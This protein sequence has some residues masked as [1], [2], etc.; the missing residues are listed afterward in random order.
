MMNHSLDG[1]LFQGEYLMIDGISFL[2]L[3]NSNEENTK[4]SQAGVEIWC[5]HDEEFGIRQVLYF[6]DPPPQSI[7]TVSYKGFHY[8]SVVYRGGIQQGHIDILR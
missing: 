4:I 5:L 7:S 1:F 6:S 2:V 8:L 3:L